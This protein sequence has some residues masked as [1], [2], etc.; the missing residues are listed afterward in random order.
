[1]PAAAASARLATRVRVAST[2]LG[3][4]CE[5]R[6]ARP[7]PHA[8]RV[9]RCFRA[10]GHMY[11]IDV[12]QETEALRKCQSMAMV[13]DRNLTCREQSQLMGGGPSRGGG[14][15]GS[16]EALAAASSASRRD[17]QA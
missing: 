9:H 15:C 8:L 3:Q 4:R 12:T 14:L 6:H 17:Q 7:L 5:L 16:L 1:M 2:R 10:I 13:R 11:C